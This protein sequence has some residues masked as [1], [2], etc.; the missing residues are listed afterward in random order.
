MFG[1]DYFFKANL[2]EK[3]KLDFVQKCPRNSPKNTSQQGKPWFQTPVCQVL[4][5]PA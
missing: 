2:D 1:L 3:M 5:L 4:P